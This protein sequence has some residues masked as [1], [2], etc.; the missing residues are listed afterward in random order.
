MKNFWRLLTAWVIMS[1]LSSGMVHAQSVDQIFS[2]FIKRYHT[3][4]SITLPYYLFVPANYD[5]RT[6]YPLVLCLH[7]AGEKGDNP[8]AVK[9]NSMAIVW[10]RDTNQ[11]KWPCFILVPQCPIAGSWVYLPGPG[12]YSS[13]VIPTSPDLS[14][15][16]DI[17]DSL[18]VEYSID[19]DRLYV[20]GLSMGGFATW[21]LIVR[22]PNKFA[23]AIPMSG[24]GDTSKAALIK[25]VP[26]WD[27]HGAMDN[28]VPVSGSREMISALERAGVPAVYTQCDNGDCTGL[29]DSVVADR[30]KSGR[31]LFY[32]EYQ[33][34]YHSIWDQ[35]YNTAFLLPWTFSQ[36]KTKVNVLAQGF[37]AFLARV[38]SAPVSLRPTIVD[39]FMAAVPSFPYNENDTTVHF[40]YRG[41]A[42]SVTVPGDANN[43]NTVAFPMTNISGTDFWYYS[44]NFE[45][46]ARLDYKFF[47]NGSNWILDPRNPNQVTGGFGPNSE[48]K[49][50]KYPEAPEI[51]Y[52]PDIPH[53]TLSDTTFTSS[54]LGNSRTVRV[55][56]P[57]GYELSSDSFAVILFHDGLDWVTLGQANNVIDYLI[58]K[59]LIPPIVAVF[60]PPVNRDAEYWSSQQ[61][62]FASFIC[63]ELMPFIDA[64]YRTRRAPGSRAVLGISAGSVVSLYLGYNYPYVFGNVGALSGANQDNKDSYQNGPVQPLRIYADVGTYEVPYYSDMT[65][66]RAI[67]QMK[68]YTCQY[69]EWHE[70]HSWG[71][72]RAHLD[73]A[74]KFFFGVQ[75]SSPVVVTGT[76]SVLTSTSATLN[77]S[78][79]PSGS[80]TTVW[81][82][83]GADSTFSSFDTTAA[84]SVGFG[85]SAVSVSANL[86]RLSPSTSYYYHVAARNGLGINKGMTR[87][88]TTMPNHAPTV[89][90]LLLP[91]NR[92]T[93]RLTYPTQ[94]IKFSWLA[95][96]DPDGD[97]LHYS[98]TLK[99]PGIDTTIFQIRDTII[100]LNIMSRLERQSA[101]SW[102]ATVSDGL[103]SVASADTFLFWTPSTVTGIENLA[104]EIPKNYVLRQNYPN[105]FNPSTTIRFSLPK[106]GYVTLKVY[107]ILGREVET[108]LNGEWTA[109]TYSVEWIPN[110]L[111]SGV[112]FYRIQAGA[113]SDVKKLMFLK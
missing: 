14:A 50:P 88:F 30:I 56:T 36:S 59:N 80:P 62:Q 2:K 13:D 25:H 48:L 65:S 71:N 19:P 41:V 79:N 28:V 34:G 103:I 91:G 7:G 16:N 38:N 67:L 106:S 35:A 15:V 46:D 61:S 84:Q 43:W 6:K 64:R 113:F 72:W 66:L 97:T 86:K 92:D 3:Y 11:T 26:I 109:G 63:N 54:I 83:W 95:S 44:S 33:Y 87:S 77:G 55:Y 47:T 52:Y 82:E 40:I 5:P 22:F 112:Y 110:N 76:A 27:F 96:S 85:G 104:G 17:V 45:S 39:S 51:K 70:G 20:T 69:N 8:S 94:S 93:V 68:G 37:D 108:L 53:G 42:S 23:A 102:T 58:S 75:P 32:T 60:V 78:V 10:A 4:Q 74:L 21:D 98:L 12:S 90:R 100:E 18:L 1:G 89:F 29:P 73:N 105:P 107:D 57:P 31:T 49:M 81:F 101:Y 9:N 24:A 99:G 111:A